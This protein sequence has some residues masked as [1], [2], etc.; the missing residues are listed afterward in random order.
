MKRIIL[1]VIATFSTIGAFA[2]VDQNDLA[3]V[4]AQFRKDKT[5]LVRQSLNLNDAQGKAFWPMYNEYET[6]RQHISAQRAGI[7]GDYLKNYDTLTPAQ[8]S[9]LVNRS[10]ANDQEGLSLKRTYFSRFVEAIGGKNAA[11][12]YQLETYI[13]GVV[14]LSVQDQIPFIGELKKKQ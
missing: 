11:K 5:E 3:V 4:Q 12:F 14:R 8:A 13:E 7:I 1:A 2:Q 6:K 10:L 9:S